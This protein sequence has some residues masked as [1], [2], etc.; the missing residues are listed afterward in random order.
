MKHVILLA[1]IFAA[2]GL[3][4]AQ[5]S[6]DDLKKLAKAGLSDEVLI[7]FVRSHGGADKLS[8]DDLIELKDAGVSD[9]VLASLLAPPDE[10]RT[11]IVERERVVTEAP[12][13]VYVERP[14]SVVYYP[15]VS[16]SIGWP[17]YS[18]YYDRCG[19]SSYAYRP[20]YRSW[21][22]RSCAPRTHFSFSSHRLGGRIASRL[23]VGW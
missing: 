3:A 4:S 10:P 6:K 16:Y 20:Y 12:T 19:Y 11:K 5:T 13:T 17:S 2:P 7:A 22:Y 18:Y 1:L 8:S 21:S 14:A 9:K 23:R 15:S